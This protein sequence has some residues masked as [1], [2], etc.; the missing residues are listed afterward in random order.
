MFGSL[1]NPL[2]FETSFFLNVQALFHDE[3]KGSYKLSVTKKRF[4]IKNFAIGINVEDEFPNYLRRDLPAFDAVARKTCLSAAVWPTG[5]F[6]ATVALPSPR[7]LLRVVSLVVVFAAKIVGLEGQF[8]LCAS[9]LAFVVD[10]HEYHLV[11]QD[12]V[13]PEY[14]KIKNQLSFNERY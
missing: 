5:D 8:F 9:H 14:D 1:L 7:L 11:W 2:L 12:K 3:P 13:F 10:S 6:H 4:D